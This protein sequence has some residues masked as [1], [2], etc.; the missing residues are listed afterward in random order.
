MA[1]NFAG[2]TDHAWWVIAP[3]PASIGTLAFWMKTTQ[4]TSNALPFSYWGA[5]SRNGWGMI[6]NSGGAGKINFQGYGVTA[7]RISLVSTTSVNDGNPHHVAV[8]YG[9]NNTNGCALYVDGN[10]EAS[11]SSSGDWNSAGTNFFMQA[12]EPVDTFWPSYVGDLWDMAHWDGS[13]VLDSAEIAALAKGF[14]PHLV[15]PA[16]LEFYAPLARDV[17]C[18]KGNALN[19]LSGTTVSAHGRSVGGAV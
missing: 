8:T 12:G 2:G 10:L 7:N 6:L 1:F 13:P 17:R 15:R 5:T 3:A 4:T 18:L 14:P 19:A 16:F 9:R 11:G